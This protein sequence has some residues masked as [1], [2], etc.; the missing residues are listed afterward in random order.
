[1]SKCVNN[2]HN[3]IK[4][5]VF[6]L[7]VRCVRKAT[8]KASALLLAPYGEVKGFANSLSKHIFLPT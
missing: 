7:R 3:A 6:L 5:K 8:A 2:I 4:D 1:M